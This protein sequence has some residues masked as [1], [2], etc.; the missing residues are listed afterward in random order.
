MR[1]KITAWG[2]NQ[3]APVRKER[4]KK[5]K[6]VL[7]ITEK[8]IREDRNILKSHLILVDMQKNLEQCG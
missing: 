5:S 2:K 7:G 1:N 8:D 6:N 4:Y 3:L